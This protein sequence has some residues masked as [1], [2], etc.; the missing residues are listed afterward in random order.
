VAVTK[1]VFV[2]SSILLAAPFAAIAGNPKVSR[3][4]EG[5]NR[6]ATVDVIAQFRHAPNQ[7]VWGDSSAT[8]AT[9]IAVNGA[10]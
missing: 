6:A 7:A 3:D 1:W 5:K 10:N 2:L 9:A 4:L 8:A